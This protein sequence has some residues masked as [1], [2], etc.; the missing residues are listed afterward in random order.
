VNFVALL[1]ALVIIK[2][3]DYM[4]YTSKYKSPLGEIILSAD[5]LG[6]TGLWFIDQKYFLFDLDKDNIE[7]ETT[8]IVQAK[9]W[10]D[11][12]FSGEEPNIKIAIHFTGT[13]FQN[14]VWNILRLIPYGKTLTYG[15][16]AK[17][18]AKKNGLK[19]MSARAVGNAIGHNKISII[20]PCHRVIGANGSLT[21]Y[22]GG[23]KRKECLLEL[24]KVNLP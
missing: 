8:I 3:R 19:R 20:V 17:L 1:L 16:I 18:L 11:I 24:E 14:E 6:L 15:E 9:K 12:Y 7:R 21:G 10:L 4:Q 23:I 22:A 5:D 13:E 2:E